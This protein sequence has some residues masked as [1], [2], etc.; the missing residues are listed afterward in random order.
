[1]DKATVWCECGTA[2]MIKGA[3]PGTT[4]ACPRCGTA[5]RVGDEDRGRSTGG[6]AAGAAIMRQYESSRNK[7]IAIVC[8]LSAVLLGLLLLVL[9][10]SS[11]NGSRPNVAPPVADKTPKVPATGGGGD[12]R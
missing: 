8:V 4:A 6:N 3:A 9:T 2:F 11:E 7:L 5:C 1:V 12:A 10:T